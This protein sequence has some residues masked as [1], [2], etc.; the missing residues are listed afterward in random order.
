ME[1]ELNSPVS[2]DH[3]TISP[4][5][6]D[7]KYFSDIL[8]DEVREITGR[9]VSEW[10]VPGNTAIP[11]GRYKIII[12]MSAKFK[13]LLPLLIGVPGFE[14]IRIHSGRDIESTE[15]CLIPG[16]KTNDNLVTDSFSIKEKL[17]AKIQTAID[18]GEEVYINIV[19]TLPPVLRN[20][21][22]A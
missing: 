22:A 2:V 11:A 7:G 5:K 17:Q 4:L 6:I 18:S 3:A 13:K 10:K 12:N 16:H 8:E 1:L 20:T 14:G 21:G 15:G 19:R 9:P